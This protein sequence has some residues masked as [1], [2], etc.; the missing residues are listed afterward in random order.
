MASRSR[1]IFASCTAQFFVQQNGEAEG[2]LTESGSPPSPATDQ[3]KN[4]LSCQARV[5]MLLSYHLKCSEVNP[6]MAVMCHSRPALSLAWREPSLPCIFLNRS[7]QLQILDN[8]AFS[9]NQLQT[10]EFCHV[11]LMNLLCKCKVIFL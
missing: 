1:T 10:Y 6:H 4:S 7:I 2:G 11:V 8:Y 3:L 5:V 9:I